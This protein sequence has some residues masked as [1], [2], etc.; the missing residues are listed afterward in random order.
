MTV[1][2]VEDEFSLDLKRRETVNGGL[3]HKDYDELLMREDERRQTVGQIIGE[4]GMIHDYLPISRKIWDNGMGAMR[5]CICL[6]D[7]YVDHPSFG[8]AIIS[9]ILESY[10]YKVGIIAQPDWKNA[11]VSDSGRAQA[12]VP[13]IG[14]K[15]GFHGESLFGFK[16]S[17]AKD[18]YTPGGEMGKRPDYARLWCTAT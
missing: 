2:A 6:G 8:H 15:H 13:G 3:L 14:R 12:G 1:C 4:Y 5:F 17:A 10:G 16:K 11:T 9:R 18:S 7:A